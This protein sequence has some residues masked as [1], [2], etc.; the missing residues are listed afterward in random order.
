V[1][2]GIFKFL[3]YF[4][5]LTGLVFLSIYLFFISCATQ[6]NSID[7]DMI[8]Y[9][10]ILNKQ[11]VLKS[12]IDTI[13]YQ[14]SLL[15]TGRVRNDI[16]LGNY[17]SKNIAETRKII[18]SDST[19]EFKFYVTLLDKTDNMLRLKNDLIKI[20]DKEQT[21]K[22]N[23]DECIEKT[24]KIVKELSRDPTRDFQTRQ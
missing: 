24:A 15:N 8:A 5:V 18:G 22:K 12:K 21:A 17:I 23:L 10:A 2:K 20:T 16:F 3:G 1:R 9:K 7:N 11:Q 14:M 6:S 19:G 4:F 13:H